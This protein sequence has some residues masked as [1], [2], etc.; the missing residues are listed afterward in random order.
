MVSPLT[1]YGDD[2]VSE[3]E[4]RLLDEHQGDTCEYEMGQ[5]LGGCVG[6][7]PRSYCTSEQH[8]VYGPDWPCR[9]AAP[10]LGYPNAATYW[11]AEDEKWLASYEAEQASVDTKGI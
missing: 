5:C 10:I 6:G 1:R 9:V 7:C 11:E 3:V 2:M 4:Q 8:K